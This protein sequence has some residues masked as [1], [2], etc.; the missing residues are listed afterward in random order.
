[1]YFLCLVVLGAQSWYCI[2]L[3]IP[4]IICDDDVHTDLDLERR[5]T[6]L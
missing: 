4:Y 6:V 3:S 1:M 2:Y 5:E